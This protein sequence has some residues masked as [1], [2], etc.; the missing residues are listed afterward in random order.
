MD[1]RKIKIL[2]VE[3]IIRIVETVDKTDPDRIGSVDF[4]SCIIRIDRD[5]PLYMR[6]QVLT[7]EIVH[8]ILY[9]L[10]YYEDYENEQKVQGLATALHLLMTSQ[11]SV[12]YV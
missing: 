5:L 6:N 3:F 11:E 2:G 1:E 4:K 10:G 12:L 9:L 7:H 8:S